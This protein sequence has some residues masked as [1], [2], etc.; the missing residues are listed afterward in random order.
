MLTRKKS[1][2]Q[3]YA[4]KLRREGIPQK[5]RKPLR[6]VSKRLAKERR[7]YSKDG[8]AFWSDPANEFCVVAASGVLGLPL[9]RKAV[10]R[11]HLD[12]RYGNKLNEKGN[13][14]A[15]SRAGHDWIRDHGNEARARGWLI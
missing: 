6:P 3:S 13:V 14:I 7:I 10:D 15:V 4:D 12:S 5:A 11:H 2:R 9:Q 1:L 8:E